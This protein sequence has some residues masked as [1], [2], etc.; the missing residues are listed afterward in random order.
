MRVLVAMIGALVAV[1]SSV[2]S[3]AAAPTRQVWQAAYSGADCE[4]STGAD[5][6]VDSDSGVV[7]ALVQ[8]GQC[9]GYTVREDLVA[10][11]AN[12]QQL[13]SA[14]SGGE[15]DF[16]GQV[17]VDPATHDVLVAGMRGVNNIDTE[18]LIQAWSSS[19]HKLWGRG[20]SISNS[21]ITV[22]SLVVDASGRAF[23]G[24]T[25]LSNRGKSDWLTS[26]YLVS[27]GATLW[28]TRYDDPAHG[29][30]V[31][32]GLAVDVAESHVYVTGIGTHSGK[33]QETTAAYTAGTGSQL[34]ESHASEDPDDNSYLHVAADPVSH[35]VYALSYPD[36][37]THDIEIHAYTDTG[38]IAWHTTWGTDIT[39]EDIAVD[40][41]TGQIDVAGQ[42]DTSAVLVAFSSTG[43]ELW[44]TS[45]TLGTSP[46]VRDLTLNPTNHRAYLT[47]QQTTTAHRRIVTTLGYTAAGAH[48]WRATHTSPIANEASQ[49]F[50]I[51]VDGM[52]KQVYVIT[53]EIGDAAGDW[54]AAT[55]AYRA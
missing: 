30:D 40:P 48:A 19:G 33:I 25:V 45:T 28:H 31:A 55:I 53:G 5:T 46:S 26:G 52:R 43:A 54:Q 8:D 20:Y 13:W 15:S 2:A 10:Y 4:G 38:A 44:A 34:W 27:S 17:A 11:S 39:P 3:A 22:N 50:A 14:N 18:L 21:S 23:V 12:G 51:T 9:P 36:S 42:T 24:A 37:D 1:L 41:K 6:A 29:Y 7:Y 35:D 47:A 32:Y 49:P 16:P